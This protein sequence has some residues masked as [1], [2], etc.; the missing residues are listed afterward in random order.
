[1]TIR[2]PLG[3]VLALCLVVLPSCFKIGNDLNGSCERGEECVCDLIGNCS[4]S[5]DGEGCQFEC[6]GTSNCVFTCEGGGCNT[7]CANTGNCI[8]ECPGGNCTIECQQNVGNCIL[9]DAEDLSRPVYQSVPADLA[10]T[11]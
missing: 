1:M 10:G 3:L 5:C 6:R 9:R 8:T 11:D 2:S 7:V 4:R